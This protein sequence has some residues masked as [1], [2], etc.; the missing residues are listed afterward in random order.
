MSRIPHRDTLV[1]ILLVV[2]TL[3]CSDSPTSS[4]SP[5]L[6][7]GQPNSGRAPRADAN[8][9]R[10]VFTPGLGTPTVRILDVGLGTTFTIQSPTFQFY[11]SLSP[12]GKKIVFVGKM[13]SGR[14]VFLMNPDG[15][16]VEP[17]TPDEYSNAVRPTYSPDGKRILYSAIDPAVNHSRLFVVDVKTRAVS[18]IGSPNM[19]AA[20][21]AWSP[22]GEQIAFG[23][24]KQ[25]M[26]IDADGTDL[27]VL[28]SGC[29]ASLCRWPS[30][31]PDGTMIAFQADDHVYVHKFNTNTAALSIW[32]AEYPS[33]SPDGT[34]LAFLRIN[35][36]WPAAG[37]YTVAL[38]DLG[39]QTAHTLGTT[40]LAGM[41][42]GP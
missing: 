22:T 18:T 11:P 42:W 20:S 15:S 31:S 36:Y 6:D 40:T 2:G 24:G 27:H 26:I 33:W 41:S 17:L 29:P 13:G 35:V 7:T 39:K 30:W 37:I 12:D 16:K 32:N 1:A 10:I 28:G 8:A 21:P 23:D 25:I 38:A 14:G 5:Q 9:G 4:R 19:T 3:A 34:K